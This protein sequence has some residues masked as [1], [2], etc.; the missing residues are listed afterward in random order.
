LLIKK[1]IYVSDLNK[2]LINFFKVLQKSP[3]ELHSIFF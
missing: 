1:G 2:S 3:I